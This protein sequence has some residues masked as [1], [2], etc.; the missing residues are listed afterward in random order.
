MKYFDKQLLDNRS[1]ESI[2]K[3]LDTLQEL[4]SDYTILG[5]YRTFYSET[6]QELLEYFWDRQEM[7]AKKVKLVAGEEIALEDIPF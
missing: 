7:E 4:V 1:L 6:M 3:Q 5:Q 2:S